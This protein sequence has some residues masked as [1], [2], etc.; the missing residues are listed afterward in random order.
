MEDSKFVKI[1]DICSKQEDV[2]EEVHRNHDNNK[3]WPKEIKDYRKRLLIAGLSTRISYNMIDTYQK[4]I[5]K[6]DIYSYEQIC[7][8]DEE[9]LKDIIRPLGLTKSRMTYIK[10]MIGFIEK[11][12][13]IINEL[14]NN[15]LIELI[16]KEV[17]GASFK[18]G[19]C[20][21]LYMRGYY[22][23][24]MPVD[25]GMKDIELPC[26]GFDYIK[27]A[28]GNKI[29]SDKISEIVKRNDFKKIIK[30]N[31]YE[32][33]NIENMNNPTWLIHL[34]L[35]YYKRLYCNKHRIDDCELNKQ[36]LAKK[37]CK[38]EGEDIER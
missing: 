29:L 33:L 12:E 22:C 7:T 25:S 38:N 3:W 9:T 16:A 1:I 13:E 8:M 32:D 18:V 6:F 26:M 31:G 11:N 14:S 35:I 20:C 34:I 21:T 24:V 19:E 27:S 37:R 17:N 5:Q 28:K 10:S 15:E 4:V 23:G 2:K 36:K 30:E